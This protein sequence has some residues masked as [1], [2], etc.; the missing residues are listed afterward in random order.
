LYVA[1]D[2][3]YAQLRLTVDRFQSRLSDGMVELADTP[4]DSFAS[5]F[6]QYWA[7]CEGLSLGTGWRKS[8]CRFESCSRHRSST[9]VDAARLGASFPRA[10]LPDDPLR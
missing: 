2:A 1:G 8:D 10:S 7:G 9:M 3:E 4:G 6:A 5:K